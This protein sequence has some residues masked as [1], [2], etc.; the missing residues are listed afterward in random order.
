VTS[1]RSIDAQKR[2]SAVVP[3]LGLPILGLYAVTSREREPDISFQILSQAWVLTNGTPVL[4]IPIEDTSTVTVDRTNVLRRTCSVVFTDA[5]QTLVS[6][7]VPS[8]LTPFGNEL[9]I[10]Y[11]VQ[12]SS[13]DQELVRIGIFEITDVDIDDSGA[14]LVIT[15]DGSDRAYLVQRAQFTDTYSI[16]PN[17]NVGL[18]IQAIILSRNITPLAQQFNFAPTTFTTPSTPIT[19]SAGDDPWTECCNLAAAIGCELFYDPNGVC[20]MIPI[21]DPTTA[22]ISWYYDEGVNN[23]AT[24]AER[25]ISSDSAYNVVIRDGSGTGVT[26]GVRGIAQDTNPASPT[27]VGGSYGS[28][29]DYQVSSLYTTDAQAQVVANADL[30]TNLG[31]IETLT[32]SSIVKPDS[33]IDDVIEVTRVRAGIPSGTKYVIDSFTLGLGVSGVLQSTCRAIS[34]FA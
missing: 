22:P 19:Y 23:I 9:E 11:G 5:N 31:T 2:S 34:S 3:R 27:Y 17:T 26:A 29:V 21:P 28:V 7:A 8:V 16:A 15:L 14:D 1:L 20:T 30:L 25:L 10:Y 12:F 32:L 4:N 33:D 6:S 24:E 18:A 13:G